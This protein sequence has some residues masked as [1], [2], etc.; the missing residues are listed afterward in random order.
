MSKEQKE[1]FKLNKN[2]FPSFQSTL[3]RIKKTK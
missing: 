2:I 3:L 1:L